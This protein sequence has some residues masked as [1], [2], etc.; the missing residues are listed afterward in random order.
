MG[1]FVLF[2]SSGWGHEIGWMQQDV[3]QRYVK[4]PEAVQLVG[5]DLVVA[6]DTVSRSESGPEPTTSFW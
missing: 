4:F 2:I 5:A 3:T 6:A 1:I